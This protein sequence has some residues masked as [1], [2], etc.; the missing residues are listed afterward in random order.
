MVQ[1]CSSLAALLSPHFFGEGYG[2]GFMC[3]QIICDSAVPVVRWLA[4]AGMRDVPGG[5]WVQS[6]RASCGLRGFGVKLIL[7]LFMFERMQ[8]ADGGGSTMLLLNLIGFGSGWGDLSQWW[9]WLICLAG[10]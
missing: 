10:L 8:I 4:V 2:F 5:N 3:W 7:S 6:I 9:L 1:I